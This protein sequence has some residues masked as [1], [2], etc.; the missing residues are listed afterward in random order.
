VQPHIPEIGIAV[1]QLH[2]VQRLVGHAPP[3]P[4]GATLQTAWIQEAQSCKPGLPLSHRMSLSIR[5]VKEPTSGLES[6]T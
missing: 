4:P 3:L 5:I 6:L 1:R 2:P